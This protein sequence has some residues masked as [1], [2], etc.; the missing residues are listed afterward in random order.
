M[1]TGGMIWI[2]THGQVENLTKMA[3]EH[4]DK[5]MRSQLGC[6]LHGIAERLLRPRQ[7]GAPRGGPQDAGQR[8]GDFAGRFLMVVVGTHFP[9]LLIVV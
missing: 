4:L 5:G 6:S 7:A 3:E 8:R 1:F 9:F 2:L